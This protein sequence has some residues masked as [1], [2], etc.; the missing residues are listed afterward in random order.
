MQNFNTLFFLMMLLAGC[1]QVNDAGDSGLSGLESPFL[2][3]CNQAVEPALLDKSGAWCACVESVKTNTPGLSSAIAS[4]IIAIAHSSSAADF[5]ACYSGSQVGVWSIQD[6]KDFSDSCL[7]SRQIDFGLEKARDFCGCW[8]ESRSTEFGSYTD[9]Q[10]RTSTTGRFGDDESLEYERCVGYQSNTNTSGKSSDDAGDVTWSFKVNDGESLTN[11]VP[12]VISY[13]I[14]DASQILRVKINEGI[15]GCYSGSWTESFYARQVSFYPLLINSYLTINTRLVFKDGSESECKSQSIVHDNIPPT[16]T[17]ISINA[18]SSFTD[19][20]NV[21][22]A[23]SAKDATQ[24]YISNISGCTFGGSWESYRT[25][26]SWFLQTANSLNKVYVM[27]K[28]HHGNQSNCITAQITHDDMPPSGAYVSIQNGA[29]T[30]T[31]ATASLTLSASGASEVYISNN[32]SCTGSAWESYKTSKMW[33]LVPSSGSAKVYVKFK[34]EAGNTSGCVSDSISTPNVYRKV[35]W[36]EGLYRP[37][38]SACGFYTSV[39]TLVEK[40]YTYVYPPFSKVSPDYDYGT[41]NCTSATISSCNG[42]ATLPRTYPG[43]Y[44]CNR[45]S[46]I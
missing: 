8:I 3:E 6:F 33:T 1:G 40:S 36:M 2:T 27:F 7:Q 28:D 29:S 9:Y 22:L 4:E 11:K 41:S 12:L 43:A 46:G 17:S 45:P 26:K 13:N 15:T 18:G 44:S 23:L 34:D 35:T 14:S 10:S 5:G 24:M 31:S 30:A 20:R 25:S 42:K 21:S 38:W 16:L 39:N 19:S 32:S 37:T